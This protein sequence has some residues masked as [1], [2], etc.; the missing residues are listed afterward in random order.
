MKKLLLFAALFVAA[1]VVAAPTATDQNWINSWK[2]HS[3]GHIEVDSSINK[4]SVTCASSAGTA[5]VAAGA[6]CVCSEQTDVTKLVKCSV[7]STT[8]TIACT[9][10]DVI[11]Y[12]CL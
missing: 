10:S 12:I 1:V 3:P 5:T 4:G 6:V 2:F 9:T 8:L 11:S 7:S